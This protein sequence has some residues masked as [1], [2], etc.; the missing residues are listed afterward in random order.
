[1]IRCS[2]RFI[3]ELE[4]QVETPVVLMVEALHGDGQR[5]RDPKLYAP[6]GVDLEPFR[7]HYGNPCRRGKLPA[8]ISTIEYMATV[9]AVQ[10]TG[11]DEDVAAIPAGP[12]ELPPEELHFLQPSRYCPSDRLEAIVQ[13]LFGP[14]GD[15]LPR[16]QQIVS[17]IH[18]NVRYQYGTSDVA[19]TAV[20]T[21][22]ARAGVCRDFSHLAIALCRASNIPARYL[23]GYCLGLEPPDLHA[24]FQAYIGGRWVCFDATAS[25]VRPALIQIGLGRDAAD[26]AW[27]TFFGTGTTRYMRVSVEQAAESGE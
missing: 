23:S 17:W 12:L 6:V 4:V 14:A 2:L 18:E 25:D 1:M 5:V 26:C 24:Y 9:D 20:D 8:G 11:C 16:V 10:C 22:L 7:D 19:T 15:P 13:D 21:L 27:S 3:V